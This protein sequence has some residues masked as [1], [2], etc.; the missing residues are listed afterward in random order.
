MT[1]Y[2]WASNETPAQPSNHTEQPLDMVKALQPLPDKQI[3]DLAEWYGLEHMDYKPFARAIE[4]AH[5]IKGEK[6]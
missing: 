3:D 6:K 2:G 1:A 5:G 4:Q